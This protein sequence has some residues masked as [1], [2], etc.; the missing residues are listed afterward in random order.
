MENSISKQTGCLK[1]GTEALLNQ[2]IAIE[3]KAAA[4]YLAMASWCDVNAYKGSSEF[5]YAQSQEEQGHMLQIFH[6]LNDAGG[7]AWQ[8][9]I[10]A[11]Q[12]NFSSLRQI[13]EQALQQEIKVTHAIHGITQHCLEQ[14]DMATFNFM[15]GF[16]K[17]QIEEETTMRQILDFFQLIGEEG[18]GLYFIDKE[19]RALGRK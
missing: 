4:A 17:E 1:Q 18:L 7:H 8:P 16:V 9:E 15:Q 14:C 19:I 11:I 6:Y 10:T 12:Q 3:A 5:L 2:Q 13:F